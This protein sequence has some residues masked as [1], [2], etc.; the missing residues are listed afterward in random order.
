MVT[1][2]D[3]KEARNRTGGTIYLSPLA[4]SET[5]SKNTGKDIFLKLDNLQMTGS[6]KERGAL[7]KLI[8]LSE[9]EHE[10]GV[11]LASAG[12]HALGV[13]YYAQKMGIPASVIM[14]EN[15]PLIKVTTTWN[16]GAEVILKGENYDESAAEAESIA[17]SEGLILVHPFNDPHVISGQGTIALEILEQEPDIQVIVV[18]VGGGGLIS[19]IAVAAKTLKPDIKIFGVEAEHSASMRESL[20]HGSITEVV[21]KSTLADGIC[22]SR[23]GEETFPIVEKYVDGMV[24]VSD[25]EI[26][27]A[28]LILLETE[29]TVAEGA[30]A[31]ALA[32][33]INKKFW[34]KERRIALIV[35]GGNID[36]NRLSLIISR[37][38]AKDGRWVRFM[39]ELP[40]VPGSL[41]ELTRI[42]SDEGANILEIEHNRAFTGAPIGLV[43]VTVSLETRGPGHIEKIRNHL[44]K[45][46][47]EVKI[48]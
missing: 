30:G 48:L 34:V 6:F 44:E 37:G 45:S 12:N 5:L 36:V 41:C 47:F 15:T 26:A 19:G 22:V 39:V 11:V 33:V 16:L 32:A 2:E 25:E 10:K 23:V 27:N 29:K 4:R 17:Q 8:S 18:P 42:V 13:S 38:L 24:T 31:A 3:V 28:I 1:F 14:P 46:D 35:S 7:N 9:K 43:E 21:V 40:D 20:E